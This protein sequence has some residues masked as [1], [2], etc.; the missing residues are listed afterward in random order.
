MG[1][2]DRDWISRLKSGL[3]RSSGK[4]SK[5]LS[6]LFTK[7]KL[8]QATVDGLEEILITG[9]LGIETASKLSRTIF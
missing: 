4:I 6:G 2:D 9:D 7:Q 5:G 8:D 3:G 1:H